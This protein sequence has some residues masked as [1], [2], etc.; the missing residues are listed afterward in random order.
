[1]GKSLVKDLGFDFVKEK[2]QNQDDFFNFKEIEIEKE[3]LFKNKKMKRENICYFVFSLG[4]S[5]F[6]LLVMTHK[7]NLGVIFN[8]IFAF[9]FFIVVRFISFEEQK[10]SMEVLENRHS[11][12]KNGFELLKSENKQMN[13]QYACKHYK[14][15]NDFVLKVE[16]FRE[17]TNMDYDLIDMWMKKLENKNNS[18]TKKSL[19]YRQ[20]P[21]EKE[22]DFNNEKLIELE[23][24][25]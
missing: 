2:L 1:M 6:A 22:F 24:K 3:T 20:S 7:G 12:A 10:E 8:A 9:L 23:G 19:A 14:E 11:K 15:I 18:K 13:I 17:I 16:S 25:I 21:S 4:F 5:V